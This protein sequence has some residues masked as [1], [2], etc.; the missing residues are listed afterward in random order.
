MNKE[1]NYNLTNKK[2]L[3]LQKQYI[4]VNYMILLIKK[5]NNEHIIYINS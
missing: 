4:L 2:H 1:Y 3:K 5:M